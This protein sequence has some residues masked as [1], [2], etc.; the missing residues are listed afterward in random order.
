MGLSARINRLEKQRPAA[1]PEK[2]PDHDCWIAFRDFAFEVL[3][4]SGHGDALARVRQRVAGNEPHIN[5]S[6]EAALWVMSQ[7]LWSALDDFP[8]ASAELEAAVDELDR[9]IQ[10]KNAISGAHGEV[11]DETDHCHMSR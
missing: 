10:E 3:A 4:A 7:T 9:K 6:S 1:P 5:W 2:N 8:A 11:C